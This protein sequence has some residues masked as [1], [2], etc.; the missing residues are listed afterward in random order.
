MPI[1]PPQESHMNPGSSLGANFKMAS[2]N[3][4]A[5]NSPNANNQKE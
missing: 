1:K 3:S 2:K 5:S 4:T